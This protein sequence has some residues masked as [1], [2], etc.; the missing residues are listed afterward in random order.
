MD[1]IWLSDI[2]DFYSCVHEGNFSK[3]NCMANFD[4]LVNLK[5]IIYNPD[6]K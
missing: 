2:M 4:N 6:P 5:Y 1:F 3:A